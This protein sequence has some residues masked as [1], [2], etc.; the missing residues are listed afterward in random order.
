MKHLFLW[1]GLGEKRRGGSTERGNLGEKESHVFS[2]KVRT[3]PPKKRNKT[4]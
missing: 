1:V 4:N 3:E 2:K